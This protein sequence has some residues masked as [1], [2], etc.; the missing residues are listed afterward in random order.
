[1]SISQEKFL[2]VYIPCHSDYEMALNNAR[3]IK[4][5]FRELN[6]SDQLCRFR[7]KINI[8]VNGL[9]LSKN[10][11][12]KVHEFADEMICYDELLG[13]DINI[14]LGFVNAL[15]EKPDYFWILSANELLV[16]GALHSITEVI[17]ENLGSNIYITNSRNRIANYETNNILLDVPPGSGFGLISSVIYDFKSM[18]PA[19]SA[20]P[21]F[22]WTGWGQLAVLQTACNQI[23][24]IK[25][26]EFPYDY[27][28]EKPFTAI[29]SD[30]P[31]SE[32]EFVRKTYAHSFFG[33]ITLVSA[34]FFRDKPTRNKIIRFWITKNWFK[35]HYFKTGALKSLDSRYPQFDS[36][37]LIQATNKTLSRLGFRVF[38]LNFIGSNLNIEFL[39]KKSLFIKLRKFTKL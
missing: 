39:R 4:E 11:I 9:K 15:I 27:L 36:A 3:K 23:G 24:K 29:N 31:I 12:D 38:I 21:R 1:M 34:L 25:V 22:A 6:Q 33:M 7:V 14:N 2:L 18:S 8:S 28:Y 19:F 26:S 16:K 35:I 32:Y 37:W 30:S 17:Q 5:Q 10:Q 20:G 13:A